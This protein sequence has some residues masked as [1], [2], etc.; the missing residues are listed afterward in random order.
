MLKLVKHSTCSPWCRLYENARKRSLMAAVDEMVERMSEFSHYEYRKQPGF[1]MNSFQS[2]NQAIPMKTLVI[3]CLD[4]AESYEVTRHRISETQN[5]TQVDRT[6]QSG[7]QLQLRAQ[8][9][10]PGIE[11]IKTILK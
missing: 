11:M 3:H 9:P 8:L 6:V 4:P 2:A 10:V 1:D 5:F 7:T